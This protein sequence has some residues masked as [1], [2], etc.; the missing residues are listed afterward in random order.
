MANERA[1]LD[2][3]ALR[4]T[5]GNFVTGITIVMTVDEVGRPR[6][7]TITLSPPSLSIPPLVLVCIG[8]TTGCFEAFQRCHSFSVNLLHDEQH[9]AS[10][11]FATKTPDKFDCV[12]WNPGLGGAPRIRGSLAMTL[13]A[14][15]APKQRSPSSTLFSMMRSVTVFSS[16]IAE[17]LL[18]PYRRLMTSAYSGRRISPGQ[19][20]SRP[21]ASVCLNVFLPSG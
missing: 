7:L 1:I 18:S 10:D 3:L 13:F 11:I 16:S 21:S 4:R 6:G 14:K 5:L 12:D 19:N 20:S 15:L 8:D 2:G 17:R 9:R